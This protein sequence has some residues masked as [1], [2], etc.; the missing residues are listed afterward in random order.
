MS[1]HQTILTHPISNQIGFASLRAKIGHEIMAQLIGLWATDLIGDRS[2]LQVATTRRETD[3]LGLDQ[4][5][6]VS[7]IKTVTC[8]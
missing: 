8:I 3:A 6:F 2:N 4:I 7:D 1:N 5:T